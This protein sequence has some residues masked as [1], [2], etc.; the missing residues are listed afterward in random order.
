MTESSVN[1][2][3][4]AALLERA[5]DLIERRADAVPSVGGMH[6]IEGS[7]EWCDW[8]GLFMEQDV[9]GPLTGWLRMAAQDYR[10]REH[11]PKLGDPNP[12]GTVYDTT[13]AFGPTYWTTALDFARQ[14]LGETP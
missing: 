11:L 10:R 4:S 2:E 13:G 14:V 5:A 1:A 8:L 7:S 9:A 12:T 3:T 6:G